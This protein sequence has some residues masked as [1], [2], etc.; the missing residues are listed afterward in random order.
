MN[1]DN[2]R[3]AWKKAPREHKIGPLEVLV[4]D[5][6]IGKALSALK[7]KMNKDGILSELKR[8]RFAEKPSEKRRRKHREAIKKLRKSR[9]RKTRVARTSSKARKKEN[10]KT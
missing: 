7:S 1:R 4:R 10:K 2:R 6:D 5:G 3:P 8:R 9:G